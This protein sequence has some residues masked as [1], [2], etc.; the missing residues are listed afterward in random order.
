MKRIV[1]ITLIFFA[2]ILLFSQ[3]ESGVITE[4]RQ[5][6]KRFNLSPKTKILQFSSYPPSETFWLREAL[7]VQTVFHLS[8]S[9]VEKIVTEGESLGWR[10]LPIPQDTLGK[11]PF[12]NS[13]NQVRINIPFD[14]DGFFLCKTVGDNVLY[15]SEKK[16]SLCENKAGSL[17]CTEAM[18]L[19]EAE[20]SDKCK[21]I[22][23]D[24]IL[25]ILELETG[26]LYTFIGSTY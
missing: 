8:S 5:V 10:K 3:C 24:Q 6:R 2:Q 14:V 4:Q 20:T 1:P 26:K 21:K 9:E 22:F 19:E 17:H 13:G 18:S 7:K 16:T 15:A 12:T 25:G 23:G 11:L